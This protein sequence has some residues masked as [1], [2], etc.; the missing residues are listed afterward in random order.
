MMAYG[1]YGK[2]ILERNRNIKQYL[3]N[4]FMLKGKHFAVR[5]EK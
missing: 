4:I 1:A 5:V 2:N 3:P